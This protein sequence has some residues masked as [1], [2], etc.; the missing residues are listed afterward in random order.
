MIPYISL[1]DTKFEFLHSTFFFCSLACC[2]CNQSTYYF[3]GYSL[4]RVNKYAKILQPLHFTPPIC[5]LAIIINTYY[6]SHKKLWV[7]GRITSAYLG[8]YPS[9]KLLN[10]NSGHRLLENLFFTTYMNCLCKIM[11]I[12]NKQTQ[13]GINLPLDMCQVLFL[14]EAPPFLIFQSPLQLVEV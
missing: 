1:Y 9:K 3:T 6:T 11:C 2:L 13:G 5:G 7:R 4:S 12:T 10:S 14:K 8:T